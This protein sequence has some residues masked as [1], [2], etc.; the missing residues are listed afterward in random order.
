MF[1]RLQRCSTRLM[2]MM[3]L[4]GLLAPGCSEELGPEH[5]PTSRVVGR[6][7]EGGNPVGGGWIEFIPTDGTVGNLRSARIGKDGSFHADRVAIGQNVIRLVNAPISIPGGNILFGKF[8]SPI[9]RKVPARPEWS[10]T[11]DLVEELVRFQATH[12]RPGGRGG[13]QPASGAQP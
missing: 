5:F 2:P 11:I 1:P 8:S 3:L 6:I 7:V 10:L 4:W 13:T 9:R 12:Q